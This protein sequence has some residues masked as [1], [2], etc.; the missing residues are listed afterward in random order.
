MYRLGKNLFTPM[1]G[2]QK[3]LFAILSV[4]NTKQNFTYR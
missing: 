2:H 3:Y 4:Q 1:S